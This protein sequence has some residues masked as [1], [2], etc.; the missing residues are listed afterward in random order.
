[1]TEVSFVDGMATLRRDIRK[2]AETLGD[3]E[4]RFLVDTYYG[5]QKFRIQ[6][7]NQIGALSEAGEP[8]AVLHDLWS[9]MHSLEDAA[10]LALDRYSTNHPMGKWMRAQKG[11]GPVIAAGLLAHLDI[12]KAPTAGHFMAFAGLDPTKEW[13]KGTKRPHN[14]QL[15]TLCWKLGESFVKVSGR[16]SRYGELYVERKKEETEK[17]AAG[18]YADQAADVLKKRKI[19]KTTEA[20]KHY[21][22]GR[23]PPAHIHARAKRWVVKIFLSNLHEIWFEEHYGRPAPS[24][25]PLAHLGHAHKI[26]PAAITHD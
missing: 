15:K 12:E 11:I 7:N 19:G 25:Y 13:K 23:L 9:G 8:V 26:A 17:N 6:L 3:G 14:G 21:S 18:D 2:A 22:A 5:V 1:M 16:G 24:P 4:A 10:K 20:Y